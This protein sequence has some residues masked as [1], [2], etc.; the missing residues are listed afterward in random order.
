M[1]LVP[2][3]GVYGA[4]LRGRA[5]RCRSPVGRRTSRRRWTRGSWRARL[6][7]SA[8]AP[9]ARGEIFNVTNGDVLNWHYAWPTVADA[10]G[11]EMGE[12][13][14]LQLAD[15]MPPRAAEW[16]DIVDRHGLRSPRDLHVF[17]G[18]SW[19]YADI[20]FG[21]LGPPRAPALLSTVKIRQAGFADCIDT[22]DMLRDWLTIFQEQRL[23]PPP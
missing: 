6:A 19:R 8:T 1:N 14:P 22:E 23:L 5:G 21:S 16:A 12:P 20:M 17:V 2:V 10:L 7:W 4:L 3:L 11:M 9:E 18:G 13:E 15:A